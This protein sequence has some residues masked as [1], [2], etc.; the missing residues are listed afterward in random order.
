[1]D[2]EDNLNIQTDMAEPQKE[3]SKKFLIILISFLMLIACTYYY[4][5]SSEKNPD[6]KLAQN[7]IIQPLNQ[8]DKAVVKKE[9]IKNTDTKKINVV[10][11]KQDNSSDK[12]DNQNIAAN[13]NV[14]G[15][16]I[17]PTSKESLIKLAL[18]STGKS[19]PFIKPAGKKNSAKTVQFGSEVHLPFFQLSTVLVSI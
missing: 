18:L 9:A 14:T 4:H 15:Q 17:K 1:M 3:N 5:D 6:S 13:A 2:Q 12:T 8:S 19:D 11:N 16:K 7:P 10:D